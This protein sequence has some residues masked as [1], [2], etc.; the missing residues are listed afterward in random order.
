MYEGEGQVSPEKAAAILIFPPSQYGSGVFY[1]SGAFLALALFLSSL[2]KERFAYLRM[3]PEKGK[4]LEEV[5]GERT[6][7]QG[8]GLL[9]L[10]LKNGIPILRAIDISA[11]VLDNEVIKS[12]L[13]KSRKDLEQGSGFGKSLKNSKLFPALMNNLIIVG[14]ESGRLDAALAEVANN[15]EHDTD[16]AMRVMGTLIEP[17]MILALGLVIG[18]MVVAMLLPVFEINILAR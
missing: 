18:F 3:S 9:E 12:Q 10:L 15:Y 6:G 8:M 11:P 5:F 2:E 16:E 7:P 13:V 1:S 4:L 17:V 14:E